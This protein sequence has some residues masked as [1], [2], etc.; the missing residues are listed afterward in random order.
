MMKLQVLVSTMKQTDYGLIEQMNI[1]SDTLVVNQCN[2]CKSEVFEHKGN[3]I[4]WYSF[5]DRGIGKSRNNALLR[6]TGDICLFADDDVTYCDGYSDLIISEFEKNSRAD[7]IIFNI[8]ST[9]A[10]RPEPPIRK[11]HRVHFYN[12]LRYGTYRIAA[13]TESIRKERLA[14][15]LLFGGGSKYGSGEDSLFLMDCIK[16][17][18]R[19]YAVPVEIGRVHHLC[20]TWFS[21]YTEKYFFDKG[22]L[23]CS[24]SRCFPKALCLQF[25]IRHKTIISKMTFR[26]AYQCMLRGVR[27]Y[28]KRQ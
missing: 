28:R 5:T 1:S 18:L 22:A 2:I 3:R 10:E 16:R 25:C 21:G 27:D 17:G 23:F 12:C 11:P 13:R 7:L 19:I 4:E 20:S 24:L 8:H 6:A 26:S 9:N 14:F 15:S